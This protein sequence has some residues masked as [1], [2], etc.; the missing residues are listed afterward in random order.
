MTDLLWDE[1]GEMYKCNPRPAAWHPPTKM[2]G[3]RSHDALLSLKRY[4]QQALSSCVSKLDLP[5][6]SKCSTGV[7][8][9]AV[10][11]QPCL[12]TYLFPTSGKVW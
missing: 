1:D 4:Q 12:L 5:V 7:I 8:R 3:K 9:S 11:A 6:P 2:T 10:P